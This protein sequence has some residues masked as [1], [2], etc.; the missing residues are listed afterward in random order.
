M[1]YSFK[2]LLSITLALTMVVLSL[3]GCGNQ[4]N[5]DSQRS[6]NSSTK[7]DSTNS[8]ESEVIRIG[9]LT[10]LTGP[11]AALGQQVEWAANMVVDL[12]NEPNP[13]YHMAFA[14]GEGLPNLNGAKIEIVVADHKSDP[15]TAV[16]EARRLISEENV[17][18]ITGEF[19]SADGYTVRVEDGLIVSIR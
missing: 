19:T 10:P 15:T 8:N 1:N 7:T 14:A 11:S 17:V 9:F 12:I 13:D 3:A 16:A 18:A 5:S 6:T 4:T 2:K